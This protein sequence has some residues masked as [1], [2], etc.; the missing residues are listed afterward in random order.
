MTREDDFK[1]MASSTLEYF[2]VASDQADLA[3]R[4]GRP[5]TANVLASVNMLN[6]ARVTQ[7][8]SDITDDQR[9]DWKKLG[10]VISWRGDNFPDSQRDLIV[11]HCS[12][13]DGRGL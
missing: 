10:R 6:T 2:G 9:A 5:A 7:T 4:A 13:A 3:L 1:A 8:L 12:W 11:I